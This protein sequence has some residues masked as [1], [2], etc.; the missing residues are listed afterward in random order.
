MLHSL[1]NQRDFT[2]VNNNG[3]KFYSPYFILV[4]SHKFLALYQK[5]NP[6]SFNT[7]D[8]PVFFGMKVS[9]K[10]G[11]AV[12][13]NKTK[14][15]IRHII[16]LL[17]KAPDINIQ[18]MGLIIIPKRGFEKIEFSLLLNEFTKLLKA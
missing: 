9:K 11:N 10:T 6:V 16:R 18:G 7:Q 2:L 17:T 13:R 4:T 8:K 14:R 3:R 1:K 5:R 15:R 12:V